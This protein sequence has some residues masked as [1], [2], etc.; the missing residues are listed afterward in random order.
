MPQVWPYKDKKEKTHS[1]RFK[2]TLAATSR[3]SDRVQVMG[4]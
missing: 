3:G 1:G 4:D 2:W